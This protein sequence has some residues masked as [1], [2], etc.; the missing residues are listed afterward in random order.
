MAEK[1]A[2]RMKY[3]TAMTVLVFI[4]CV[5]SSFLTQEKFKLKTGFYYL[6]EKESEGELIKGIDSEDVFAVDRKEVLTSTD[7][8]AIQIVTKNFNSKSINVIEVKLS[9]NGKKKWHEINKRISQS[10]ESILF[11]CHDKVYLEKSIRGY[12]DSNQSKILLLIEPNHQENIFEII[13][14]EI[15]TRH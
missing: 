15:S 8:S 9:K 4:S 14:S 13:K 3:F 2:K 1:K 12:N 7:F 10:G 5:F 6:A 11:I